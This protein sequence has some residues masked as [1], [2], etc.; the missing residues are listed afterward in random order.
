MNIDKVTLL[1]YMLYREA[2]GVGYGPAINALAE[3]APEFYIKM[4]HDIDSIKK[5]IGK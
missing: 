4:Q 5:D 1:K 3:Q 2:G